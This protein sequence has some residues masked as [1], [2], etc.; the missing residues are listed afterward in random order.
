M[1]NKKTDNHYVDAKLFLEQIREY[2]ETDE[3]TTELAVHLQNIAKGLSYNYR[4]IGYTATWKDE[5]VGDA[6][7]KMYSALEKKLYK[8]DS[9]FSPFAYFNAIAWNAFSNRIKKEKKE[10]DGLQEYRDFVYE[11]EMSD[12]TG[13]S[14]YVK[15]HL[16]ADEN[17]GDYE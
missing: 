17:D 10:H 1:S 9:G 11:N 13:G 3:M 7:L 8:V 5:M 6:I 16:E 12:S 2:Y 15:P 14:V 4:F